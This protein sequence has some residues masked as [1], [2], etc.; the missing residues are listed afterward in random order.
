MRRDTLRDEPLA[1]RPSR[2]CI[3]S[4]RRHKRRRVERETELVLEE[5]DTSPDL[6]LEEPGEAA[7]YP[8]EAPDKEEASTKEQEIWDAFREEQYESAFVCHFLHALLC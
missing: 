6:Q 7:T 4:T 3:M 2:F 1:L 8:L 5:A